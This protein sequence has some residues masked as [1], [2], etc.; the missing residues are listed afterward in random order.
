MTLDWAT[1]WAIARRDLHAGFRGLRLLFACLFLGVATLAAIG[2]LTAAITSELGRR[3]Q[4]LLGG[5][6]EIGISQRAATPEELKR[7]VTDGVTEAELQDA[8]KSIE[9]Q[10][11][12]GRSQDPA[13]ASLQLR[14][15][16]IG[17]TMAFSAQSDA[18]I[19][20]MTVADV[21]AAIKKLIDPAKLLH[22]YAG[23]FEGA[24]KKAAA[25]P[26]AAPAAGPGQ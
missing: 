2:S 1:S 25:T 8:K 23:D 26:A 10:R 21:N 17:R 11:K 19:A 9:Q 18:R 24:S 16:R 20:A 7:F 12:A 22:V 14:N 13:L 6:L 15:G 5:D 4:T 3:G